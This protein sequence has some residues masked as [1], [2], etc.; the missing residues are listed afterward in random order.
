MKLTL[1]I[2]A[3]ALVMLAAKK[4][5]VFGQMTLTGQKALDW[6]KTDDAE[7]EGGVTYTFT[8]IRMVITETLASEGWNVPDWKDGR[9]WTALGT[10]SV[11]EYANPIWIHQR[12]AVQAIEAKLAE[13]EAKGAKVDDKERSIDFGDEGVTLNFFRPPGKFARYEVKQEP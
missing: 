11:P 9:T 1:M 2:G 8:K 4:K 10:I 3:M 13:W 5:P 7:R 12:S 6:L